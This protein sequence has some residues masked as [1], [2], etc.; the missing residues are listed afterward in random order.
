MPAFTGPV[1]VLSVSGGNI[2]FGDTAVIS[3]KNASKTTT[4][5]GSVNT[6]GFFFTNTFFSIN[7]TLNTSLL[8]QPVVGNN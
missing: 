4:G 7:G 3:P 5:S 1:S 2:Q 6:G 8:D